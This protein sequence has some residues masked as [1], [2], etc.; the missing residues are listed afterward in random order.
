MKA[1]Q[2]ESSGAEIQKLRRQ[3]EEVQ[4]ERRREKEREKEEE[5]RHIKTEL[6][7]LE[8]RRELT[9]RA[10]DS[11]GKIEELEGRLE[12][13]TKQKTEMTGRLGEVQAEL[14]Q[15]NSRLEQYR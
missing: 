2:A 1:K 7:E 5:Q 9:S 10:L 12:V 15:A 8:R 11:E 4:A 6:E 13:C 14:N 3:L